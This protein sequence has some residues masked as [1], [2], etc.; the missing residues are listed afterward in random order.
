VWSYDPHVPLAVKNDTYN[1][2]ANT[3][4]QVNAPGVLVNDL[5]TDGE[6]VSPVTAALTTPLS[7]ANAGTLN[8][9]SDGSFVLTPAQNFQGKAT[10]GYGASYPSSGTSSAT[11]TINIGSNTAPQA[12]GDTYST[13]EDNT[14]TIDRSQGVLANDLDAE[15]DSL[16]A[17]IFALP[18]HG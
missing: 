6:V 2:P 16:R 9:K 4:L 15:N 3:T 14:L 7:P 5:D 11:V 18:G 1:T 8:F 12:F 13:N 10:F 17:V